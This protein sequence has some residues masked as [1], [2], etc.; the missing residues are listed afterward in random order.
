VAPT[1]VLVN[2]FFAPT[3]PAAFAGA[4]HGATLSDNPAAGVA[5][6]E[7]GYKI[8]KIA[9]A[10][11]LGSN[12]FQFGGCPLLKLIQIGLNLSWNQTTDYLVSHMPDDD[13]FVVN[14]S[15]GFS[16][17][18]CPDTGCVPPTDNLN[19]PVFFADKA[20]HWKEATRSHWP[21]FLMVVSAGNERD[22]ESAEIYP[23]FSDSRYNS[24][25]AIAQLADNSFQFASSDALWTPSAESALRGF[26]SLKASAVEQAAIARAVTDAGL[27]GPISTEDN[28]IVVGSVAPQTAD[29]RS[30]RVAPELLAESDFSD[31]NADLL[32]IGENVF[33]DR[34]TSVAAPQITGLVSLLWMLS[35]ELRSVLP[36]A[37]TK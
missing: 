33:G 4:F 28:V 12:P 24:D 1:Q 36:V 30:V 9:N 35:P 15:A 21:E 29:V 26:Q 22:E 8:A 6:L 17:Q 7:H 34:G 18:S 23:G 32:T 19:T 3:V 14:L 2:D 27:A 16:K 20:L 13:R 5:D 25:V 31:S 11:A 10:N 37:T